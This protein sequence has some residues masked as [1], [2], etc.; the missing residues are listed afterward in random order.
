[1]QVQTTMR[2]VIVKDRVNG[3]GIWVNKKACTFYCAGF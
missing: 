1:M 3:N 2:S